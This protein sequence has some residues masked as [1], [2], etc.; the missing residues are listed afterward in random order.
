MVT[1]HFKTYSEAEAFQR[2]VLTLLGLLGLEEKKVT[3]GYV[4]PLTE[5]GYSTSVA[6]NAQSAE[7]E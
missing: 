7:R 6:L 2:G 4:L 5:A 3:L 1:A